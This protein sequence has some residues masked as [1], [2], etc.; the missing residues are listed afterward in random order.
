RAQ[1][2]FPYRLK[3]PEEPA[4]RQQ[5]VNQEIAVELRPPRVIIV[6]EEDRDGDRRAH[7]TQGDIADKDHGQPGNYRECPEHCQ[8][9]S[10]VDPLPFFK[11]AF[12]RAYRFARLPP[13]AAVPAANSAARCSVASEAC[14]NRLSYWSCRSC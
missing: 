1:R 5:Q 11:L 7:I 2:A 14:P 9:R 10:H 12:R 13:G 6:A 8:T 3:A 4:H